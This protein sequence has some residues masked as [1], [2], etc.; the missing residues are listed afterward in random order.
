MKCVAERLYN[1]LLQADILPRDLAP[2][3]PTLGLAVGAGLLGFGSGFLGAVADVN[4][5]MHAFLNR[6]RP[7]NV[8]TV[9]EVIHR[10]LSRHQ[11][12]REVL[13]HF[14][15]RR[16]FR[17]REPQEFGMSS[18]SRAL[19]VHGAIGINFRPSG[20][21]QER[22]HTMVESR[23]LSSSRSWTRNS[24]GLVSYICS[25]SARKIF[26]PSTFR[27][28]RTPIASARD[29][30]KGSFIP[31][32]DAANRPMICSRVS[33]GPP[34]RWQGLRH[35]RLSP[36]PTVQSPMEVAIDQ[37]LKQLLDKAGA[38]SGDG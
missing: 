29:C 3:I 23:S 21:T 20:V 7:V 26:A 19:R 8:K 38:V 32:S 14:S 37:E 5:R 1:R 10:A 11:R 9:E 27:R 28:R 4:W 16:E 24:V 18:L 6:S 17:L 15:N 33:L 30:Q 25:S 12:R 22:G 34:G 31:L 2:Q 13:H 36:R 35:P